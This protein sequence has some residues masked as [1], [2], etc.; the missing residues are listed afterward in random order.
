MSEIVLQAAVREHTGKK[1]KH[2]RTAGSVPGVF[3]QH[4]EGTIPIQVERLSLNPLI[5]TSETHV[6]QLRLADGTVKKC[7]LRDVQFDPVSDRP[8]HF[9]LQGLFENER[10]TLEIPVSLTGGVPRGVR[11]GGMLQHVIHKLR[12]SCFPRDIPEKIEVN[13]A[14]LGINQA[15]HV[16]DLSLP[17]V[18][19]LEGADS[20]V[21][22]VL[23][24]TVVKEEAVAAAPVEEAK[25]PEV[26]GKGKKAEEGAEGE[27]A[28]GAKK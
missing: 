6:I 9:D 19:I 23:P 24:P 17:E 25:E 12:V 1:A 18:T 4:G 26:V 8:V 3:Y 5:Y 7:I 20:T 13:I 14:D 16:S 15:V 22:A 28:E 10:L 27:A 11:D 2:V 21:V